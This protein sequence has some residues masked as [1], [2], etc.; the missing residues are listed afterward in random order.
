MMKNITLSLL[1][2]I[3]LLNVNAQDY[4]ELLENGSFEQV[5]GKIKKGGLVNLAVNWMSPTKSGADLYSGKVKEG[6]SVPNNPMGREDAYDGENYAGFTAFSYG[7]KE[8]RTY[9]SAKLKTPMRGGLKYCVKFYISL[10]EGSK[11]ASNNIAANFSKKQFNIP[12]DKSIM[13]E[14]S[15]MK[16]GN[17]IFNATFGWDEI[18]GVYTAQGGE[19]FITIGNFSTNG[20]TESER[21]KK[22]KNF[23][24]QQAIA[25]YYYIDNISVKLIEEESECDCQKPQNQDEE[26]SIVYSVSPVNPEGLKDAQIVKYSEV[27]FAKNKADIEQGADL[28][29]NNIANVMLKN[30]AYK[31]KVSI[32]LSADEAASD[33][34]TSI[35]KLRFQAIKKYLMDKGIDVSR[36]SAEYLKDSK[37]KD[38]SGSDLGAAKNRRA[39]FT[40]IE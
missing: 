12:E 29:L 8:P 20:D 9:V 10:A 16:V 39:N 38:T 35:E 37:P 21:L 4:N 14:S 24:G 25:A 13:A 11:Y 34:A 19:K 26:T 2:A 17:P 27:Y 5:E 40:L 1:A 3:A 15:V 31:L 33:K 36:I 23:S 32:N 18:C 28:H 30:P 22:P 7:D 6:Y